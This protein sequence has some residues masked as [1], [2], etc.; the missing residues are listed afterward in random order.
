[1]TN[2]DR[3]KIFWYLKRKTSYMAWSREVEIFDRFADVFEKQVREQPI[4]AGSTWRRSMAA[5]RGR[6]V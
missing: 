1:M 3:R 5:W 2:D 4:V 6:L